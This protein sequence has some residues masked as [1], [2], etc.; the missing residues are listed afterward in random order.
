MFFD[1]VLDKVHGAFDD[2]CIFTETAREAQEPSESL[3]DAARRV[4]AEHGISAT[5]DEVAQVVQHASKYI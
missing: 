1:K 3:E 2:A 5:Y 4:L